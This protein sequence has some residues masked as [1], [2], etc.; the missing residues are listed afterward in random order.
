MW[1]RECHGVG[2]DHNDCLVQTDRCGGGS[3]T[4]WGRITMPALS[5]RI[6]VVEGVSRCGAGSQCLP[7][8]DGSMWWR[9]C[10]G[11]GRDHNACLVQTDRCGGVS[12]TVWGVITMPALSRRID[13]VEGVSRCGECYHNACLVQTDRCGGGSVTVWGMLSQ[14]L[15]WPDGSMWWRECHGVGNVIT[16]TALTRRIDVVEGV[17]RCGAWSQCL[18]WPDGSMWWRECHGVGHDHNDCLD[19]TDRCGGGS[20]TVWGR[21]TMPALTRR[22][23][24]VEG[25]SR[26]GAG[27]QCLPCPDGSMWWREC[28]GVGQDHNAC[29]V[30]TDRCGGGS[31]TVWGRITM[32][33]L[34]RRIDVVEGVSR[35]GAGSQ[36]LPWPD[37][38]MWWRECHGVGR[39]HNAC[40]VQTDRCGGGSVT[41]WGVITMPALSRRIN[42][43]EG[44]SRCGAWSQC[45]PCPDGSMWWRE[46]HGVGRDHNDCLDQTDRCGGGSVTV[47]RMLSQWLPWPD[48]SMWWRE[49]HGVGRDHNAC[50][51]QTDQCGGGSVTVWRMLSQWLPWPDG[52]MWWRECHGVGRDHNACL[53]QTDRWGGGSVTVWGGISCHHRTALH[54]CCDRINAIYYWDNVLRIHVIPLFH[55]HQDMHTFQQD[56]GRVHTAHDN[57]VPSSRQ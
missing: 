11:V 40:L 48:G 51:V 7:C 45:L 56:N 41:V 4:V 54:V 18:P 8:P 52:S 9:E 53:V 39:D 26:C 5:R 22:I 57:T 35:C 14:W 34:S 13:G 29:L 38:S 10:H 2:R 17:S 42:V 6:D 33:A 32:P 36:C 27:S 47:W 50:L 23:D 19:Q 43:V 1:W 55:Q 25:V 15:P 3:V 37:G 31:V 24:V 49:C 12:V 44:V 28:H 46:C 21:I 20:V 16:M 30:Q